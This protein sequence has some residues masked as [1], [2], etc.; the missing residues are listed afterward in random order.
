MDSDIFGVFGTDLIWTLQKIYGD[1]RT[2]FICDI[3][4]EQWHDP[5]MSTNEPLHKYMH[6]LLICIF[7]A[8]TDL[9]ICNILLFSVG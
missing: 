6:A 2:Y 8:Y 5:M 1:K 7:T 4:K 9:H 3:V